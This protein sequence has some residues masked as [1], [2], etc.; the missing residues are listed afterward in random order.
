MFDDDPVRKPLPLQAQL[1]TAS[2]EELE[3]RIQALREE[4]AVCEQ[5]IE[6][7]RAQRAA[8]DSIFGA[9]SS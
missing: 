9:R 3:R 8:A 4:I 7:K 2:I 1:E 6:A 5:A